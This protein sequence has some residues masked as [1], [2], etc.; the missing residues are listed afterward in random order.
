MPCYSLFRDAQT[1]RYCVDDQCFVAHAPSVSTVCIGHDLAHLINA[2][3]KLPWLPG[4]DRIQ[5]CWVELAAVLTEQLLHQASRNIPCDAAMPHF[6]AHCRWFVEHHYKPFPALPEIAWAWYWQRI[7]PAIV[8]AALPLYLQVI[9]NPL[10]C[11][12]K[13]NHWFHFAKC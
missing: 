13:W 6:W 8:L 9:A 12:R 1:Q 11:D 2:E 10:H 7:Q 3:C 4:R 5:N